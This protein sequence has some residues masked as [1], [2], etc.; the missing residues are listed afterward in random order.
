METSEKYDIEKYRKKKKRKQRFK[1]LGIAAGVILVLL[2]IYC[3]FEA[4]SQNSSFFSDE[5][6]EFPVSLQGV[7]PSEF[8]VTSQG[9]VVT[10]ES[11][12]LFFSANAKKEAIRKHGFTLPVVQTVGNK[13]L[14]Y[15]QAGKTFRVDT[16]GGQFHE[17]VEM[18][19][20]ILFCKMDD[21]GYIA[22]VTFEDRYNGSLTIFDDSF[23]EIY[24]YNESQYYITAFDFINSQKGVMAVQ[25][26]ENGTFK[27]IVYGLDF[28]KKSK[29]EFFKTEIDD[30]MTLDIAVQD[31]GNIQVIGDRQIT[32]LDKQGEILN[33][34][35]FQND[36]RLLW[37]QDDMLVLGLENMV[38]SNE[39]DI[40]IM[41]DDGTLK[42]Q[43]KVNSVLIDI[44]CCDDQVL[45]LD[46]NNIYEY[47]DQLQLVN[48]FPNSQG[49]TEI[50]AYNHQIYGISSETLDVVGEMTY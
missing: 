33:T 24:K 13:V 49:F 7:N 43:T 36:I 26:A 6:N 44:F 39:T 27:T 17:P 9:L 38:D 12:N 8:S 1:K 45:L 15:D 22:A 23:D 47:D 34:H 48:T 10:G 40:V 46:K 50:A 28:H 20:Q 11:D 25:T 29:T 21:S 4:V 42:A 3:I 19:N 5:T 18:D 37:N 41:E 35:T 16:K 31:N 14:T 30:M 2:L 32:T